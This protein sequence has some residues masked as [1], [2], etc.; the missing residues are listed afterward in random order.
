M[1][2]DAGAMGFSVS[3]NSASGDEISHYAPRQTPRSKR[4]KVKKGELDSLQKLLL[5]RI[6]RGLR[7]SDTNFSLELPGSPRVTRRKAD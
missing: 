3:H 5:E 4:T 2:K 6:R 1:K 7:A